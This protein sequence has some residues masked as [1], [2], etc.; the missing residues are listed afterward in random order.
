MALQRLLKQMAGELGTSDTFW[1]W[2]EEVIS[3]S[4]PGR[5]YL[6]VFTVIMNWVILM[7][8]GIG[9]NLLSLPPMLRRMQSSSSS[10][11]SSKAQRSLPLDLLPIYVCS[12]FN[13]RV[14]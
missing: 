12:I 8:G 14:Y 6:K 3:E 11:A 10:K 9:W 13:S 4:Q 1:G 2:K 5:M 7:R